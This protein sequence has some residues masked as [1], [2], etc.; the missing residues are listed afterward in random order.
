[1]GYHDE[2][3]MAAMGDGER[4]AFIGW[5]DER[6]KTGP[7]WPVAA[8]FRHADDSFSTGSVYGRAFR[9]TKEQLGGRCSK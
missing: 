5:P 1:L 4:D 9:E 3:V 2:S 6:L 8:Q 7:S